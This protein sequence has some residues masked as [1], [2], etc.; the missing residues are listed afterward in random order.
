MMGGIRLA[1][2]PQIGGGIQLGVKK[3]L[4]Y[5][6]RPDL[7]GTDGLHVQTP[8]AILIDQ[9]GTWEDAQIFELKPARYLSQNYS[10]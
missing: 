9:F 7:N 3:H 1:T 4:R 8:G 10:S 5:L 6:K 2:R